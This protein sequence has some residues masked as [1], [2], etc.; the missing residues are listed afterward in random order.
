[1]QTHIRKKEKGVQALSHHGGCR[2]SNWYW[3]L[4]LVGNMTYKGKSFYLVAW[5]LA[6]AS[7]H[8][9]TACHSAAGALQPKQ[10][11]LIWFSDE[12]EKNENKIKSS[13]RAILTTEYNLEA[14]TLM[15]SRRSIVNAWPFCKGACASKKSAAPAKTSSGCQRELILWEPWHGPSLRYLGCSDFIILT[16]RRTH[17]SFFVVV[18][19]KV[20]HWGWERMKQSIRG[21][22]AWIWALWSEKNAWSLNTLC[23]S[24]WRVFFLMPAWR[25]KKHG[26]LLKLLED[27]ET[28][29]RK[30]NRTVDQTALL[31]RIVLINLSTNSTRT[32]LY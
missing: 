24:V 11:I 31:F 6:E 18:V 30:V 21:Q 26:F 16:P 17:F 7:R 13:V 1:M 19:V 20:D 2:Q 23:L 29:L 27:Y 14:P 12:E 8:N 32:L 15:H 4:C 5:I 3:H 28:S 22:S 25:N 9:S 10:S